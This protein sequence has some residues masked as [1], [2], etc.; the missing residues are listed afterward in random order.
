MWIAP[1]SI[2]FNV[3]IVD[4]NRH[5]WSDCCTTSLALSQEE[6]TGERVWT[7]YRGSCAWSVGSF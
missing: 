5:R 4:K 3:L 1:G 7:R 2:G 6:G